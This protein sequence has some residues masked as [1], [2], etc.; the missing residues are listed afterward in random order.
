MVKPV[1]AS[2]FHHSQ[3]YDLLTPSDIEQN[4]KKQVQAGAQDVRIRR[5]DSRIHDSTRN[6]YRARMDTSGDSP[7][8]L[9]VRPDRKIVRASPA[10]IE[11]RNVQK[12]THNAYYMHK[13]SGNTSRS[14]SYYVVII[15][16]I[17]IFATARILYFENALGGH[18]PYLL[19]P[20][21]TVCTLAIDAQV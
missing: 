11:S 16:G 6:S 10:N 14:L 20:F 17:L 13:I 18:G 5:R 19:V 9:K 3:N 4:V 15:M 8:V 7:A 1:A 2:C 21:R 12:T